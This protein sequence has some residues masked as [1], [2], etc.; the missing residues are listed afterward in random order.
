MMEDSET[1]EIRKQIQ[2]FNQKGRHESIV[3]WIAATADPET[4]EKQISEALEH[5]RVLKDF[6]KMRRVAKIS[7]ELVDR[8]RAFLFVARASRI[9]PDIAAARDELQKAMREAFVAEDIAELGLLFCDLAR[10]TH[11]ARDLTKA[12]SAGQHLMERGERMYALSVWC[13]VASVHSEAHA[14]LLAANLTFEIEEENVRRRCL[15][16]LV[17]LLVKHPPVPAELPLVVSQIVLNPTPRIHADVKA[18]VTNLQRCSLSCLLLNTG[19][20]RSFC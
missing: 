6:V 8:P 19:H 12:G 5:F 2:E 15:K 17:D 20:I 3:R 14:F 18:V 9:G 7:K 16:A 4:R 13:Q 11:D 1:I 10:L